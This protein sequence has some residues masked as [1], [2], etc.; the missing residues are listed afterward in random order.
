VI[1]LASVIHI[2][3]DLTFLYRRSPWQIVPVFHI[4]SGH[5]QSNFEPPSG[6][7][8]CSITFPFLDKLGQILS[9]DV[10]EFVDAG[11]EVAADEI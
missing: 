2:F 8:T 3:P 7:G 6:F 9:A 10:T 4:L 5:N 1:E 11:S